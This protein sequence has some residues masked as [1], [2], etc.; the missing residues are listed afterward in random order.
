[1]KRTIGV[2]AL[3]GGFASH[4][5][6]LTKLGVDTREVRTVKDLKECDGL[7]LPGGESTVMTNLLLA[8]DS[9]FYPALRSFARK[10]PVMGTCAGLILLARPGTDERV[11]PLDVL[12][13]SVE[14]NSYG[15]QTESFLKN[16]HLNFPETAENPKREQP[17]YPATFI[18]APRIINIEEG[19]TVLAV[20]NGDPVMVQYEH[21]LGLT[22]HPELTPQDTR[23]H[24][25]FLSI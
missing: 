18:R 9:S 10:F 15:R 17:P 7:V 1:M 21:I 12:P 13:V 25:Y 2:L 23:I 20:A 6:V 24:T 19:V 4:I 5:A 11:V 22:F 8:S 14:R 3:Q 16:I